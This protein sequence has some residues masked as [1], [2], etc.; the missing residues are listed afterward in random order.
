MKQRLYI[1]HLIS[2]FL[3]VV[4]PNIVSCNPMAKEKTA[5]YH[6]RLTRFDTQMKHH[7]YDGN[8][9]LLVFTTNALL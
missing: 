2:L 8:K 6:I 5:I 1:K 4:L 3:N 9:Y 7:G